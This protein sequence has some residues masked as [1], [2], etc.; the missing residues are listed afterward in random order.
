MKKYFLIIFLVCTF[1]YLCLA[2]VAENSGTAAFSF[3]K[4]YSGLRAQALG[5]SYVAVDEGL[6]TIYYNPAGL[7]GNKNIELSAECMLWLDILT[8]S[9]LT[10]VYPSLWN[11][12]NIGFGFDYIN[13][14]YEKRETEDDHNYEQASVNIGVLYLSYA[15]KVKEKI[16]VGANLKF[17]V[18]SFGIK[19]SKYS[20]TLGLGIDI[21]GIYKILEKTNIGLVIKNLGK[22][23][24]QEG[25]KEDKMPVGLKL[26]QATKFVNDKLLFVSDIDWSFVDE[27]ISLGGGCE[28]KLSHYFYPRL[29]YRYSFTNNNLSMINGLNLGFGIKYKNINFDYAFTPKDDLG[30]SHRFALGYSF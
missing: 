4:L 17:I 3:L 19:D 8:K 24:T 30:V 20:K 27:V 9:N 22:E 7:V 10:F 13:I 29:G 2:S 25:L 15:R 21:G 18:Q 14:P 5:E 26:G 6:D 23:F 12:G 1:K 11:I 16:L 28:Y